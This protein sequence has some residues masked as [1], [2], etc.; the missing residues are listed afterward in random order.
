[1]KRRK[2][3][4]SY[5]VR[6]KLLSTHRF[7]VG[8]SIVIDVVSSAKGVQQVRFTRLPGGWMKIEELA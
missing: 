3:L 4:R 2:V 7:R 8:D 1:M 5:T 6:Y